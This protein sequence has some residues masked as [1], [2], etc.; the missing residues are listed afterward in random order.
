MRYRAGLPLIA[1]TNPTISAAALSDAIQKERRVELF[2]EF[3]H[4]WFDMKRTGKADII[5][6][7]I[8]P[9]WAQSDTLWPIPSSQIDL[10]RTLTQNA[11]Y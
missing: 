8:K 1:K 4:R 2:A 3:G 11:G 9:K 10:N 7:G 6:S 5:L